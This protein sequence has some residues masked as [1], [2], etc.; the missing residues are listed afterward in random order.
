MDRG[1]LL[2]H[3]HGERSERIGL[4]AVLASEATDVEQ[5]RF[6]QLEPRRIERQRIGRAR[7]L[8]FCIA[9]FDQRPVERRQRFGE[10]GMVGGAALD[11]PAGLTQKSKR[12]LRAAEQLI[13]SRPANLRP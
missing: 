5:P 4:D 8:V 7:D 6:D 2:A 11:P 9:R 10:Q 1:Q 13:E 3:L 12:A